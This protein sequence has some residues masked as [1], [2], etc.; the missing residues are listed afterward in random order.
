MNTMWRRSHY[1]EI[2][3]AAA[4]SRHQM[5]LDYDE[6]DPVGQRWQWGMNTAHVSG[7]TPSCRAPMLKWIAEYSRRFV[8]GSEDG[9]S[10]FRDTYPY[11]A[12][13]KQHL[14][15]RVKRRFGALKRPSRDL[16]DF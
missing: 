8:F 14:G 13:C 7:M 2:R 5:Y 16:D 6:N 15:R 4:G 11:T 3:K 12:R 9:E 1:D 10:A